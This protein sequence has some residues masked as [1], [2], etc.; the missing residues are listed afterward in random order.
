MLFMLATLW[1]F[2]LDEIGEATKTGQRVF[3]ILLDDLLAFPL[4]ELSAG[5]ARRMGVQLTRHNT[6]TRVLAGCSL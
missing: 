3:H 6:I 1:L 4:P 2:C 5:E